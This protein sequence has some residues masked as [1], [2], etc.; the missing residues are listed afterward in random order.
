MENSYVARTSDALLQLQLEASGAVLI[1]GLKWCGKTTS[2]EQFAQ[3]AVYLQDTKQRARN[4]QLA[5]TAP[6]VLLAGQSPRL[7]DEWQDAP[8]LWDAVRHEVDVRGGQGQ[9][10]LTG[11]SVPAS[12]DA[13][14]HSGTGRIARLRMRTIS[15]AESGDSTGE[16]SL[17]ELFDGSMHAG[18]TCSDGIESL[19]YLVCRGGWPAVLGMSERGA[20]Q[21]ALNYVDAVATEDISRVDGVRRSPQA[22]RALLR[23]YARMSASQGTLGTMQAD[24]VASG[25][26]L[27]ESA[28]GEYVEALRR[29]FVIEDLPAWNPNLRSKTAIRTSPTRHFTDSSIAAAALGATPSA[30]VGDPETLGLLLETMAVRDLRCYA[31][32][33]D[34]SVLHYR[35]KTNLECDAVIVLRDGRYGLVEVK[36]GRPKLIEEGATTLTKLSQRI[37]TK[38]MGEPSFLMI[39]T[40]LGDMSYQ[41]SDGVFVA[42]LRTLGV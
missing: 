36:L 10:L 16:V 40:G 12:F 8:G 17:R 20:L 1:E 15:L 29:L 7:I 14:A 5:D 32:A 34:G 3:S 6:D 22:A 18:A 39:L 38:G 28:F 4:L 33:L 24:M 19:A 31:D 25:F 42:P 9:F 21:Q 2:A 35:D 41:R 30:L 27:G 11:S 13:T 26:T 37:D 23:S